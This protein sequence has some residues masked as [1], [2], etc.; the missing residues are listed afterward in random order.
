MAGQEVHLEQLLGKRVTDSLGQHVGHI[1]EV[2]AEQQEGEWVIVEYLVGIAAIVERFSAWNLGIS[3]LRLLGSHKLPT[4]L[5]IP[6]QQLDLSDPM[7]PQL[8]CTLAELK[9]M[10]NQL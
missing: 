2:R 4:G 5:H 1:Q 7:H 9:R 8:H 3:F 10:T 6:W